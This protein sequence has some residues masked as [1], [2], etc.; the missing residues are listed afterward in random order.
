MDT[1][2]G[3][4]IPS[5]LEELLSHFKTALLVIDLQ[6]DFCSEGGISRKSGHELIRGAAVINQIKTLINKAREEGL[7]IIY[8]LN[9]NLQNNLSDSS[10]WMRHRIRGRNGRADIEYTIE[11]TWGHKLVEEIEPLDGEVVVRKHRASAFVGTNLDLILRSNEIRTLLVTGIL[12]ESC[13]DSTARDAEFYDYFAVI[14]R[15]C[16]DSYRRDLH[17]ACLKIM[18]AR[19]EVS[20]SESIMGLW[21]GRNLAVENRR[22]KLETS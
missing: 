1:L 12:T 7:L 9:T 11:G 6:N 2:A 15:D 13:V 5:A 8:T 16:I 18:E 21:R 3:K 4:A 10:A 17:E 20:D 14:L 19:F 22:E